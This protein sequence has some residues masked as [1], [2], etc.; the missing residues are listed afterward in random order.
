MSNGLIIVP[1]IIGIVW[2]FATEGSFPSKVFTA[3]SVLLIIVAIIMTTNITLTRM[4]LYEWV[5]LL[6]LIFG[7]TGLLARLL[8][9]GPGKKDDTQNREL[10]RVDQEL[11]EKKR[12]LQA[13]EDELENM[14]QNL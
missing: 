7:G 8:L 11:R 10:D 4:T 12:Q 5:L 6:V 3:A 14:K 2:M 13:I 9:A 1:L